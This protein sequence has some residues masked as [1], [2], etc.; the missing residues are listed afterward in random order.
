MASWL[1]MAPRSR[2]AAESLPEGGLARRPAGGLSK[3]AGKG[4]GIALSQV[5][6]SF[7]L[8]EKKTKNTKK[9]K[10]KKEEAEEKDKEREDKQRK[11][12][13]FFDESGS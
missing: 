11:Q 13:N 3:L 9:T 6:I 10:K 7:V 5:G 2:F 1:H 12:L 4:R 8:H